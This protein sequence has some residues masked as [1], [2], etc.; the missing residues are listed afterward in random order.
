MAATSSTRTAG[1][2]GIIG[3]DDLQWMIA[4]RGNVHSEMPVKSQTRA[5]STLR[6]PATRLSP[7]LSRKHTTGSTTSTTAP[8]YISDHGH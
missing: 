8:A 6:C 7:K 4:G 2:K 5:T 1:H 3:P